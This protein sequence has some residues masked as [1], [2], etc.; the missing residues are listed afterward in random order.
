MKRREFLKQGAA[1]AVAGTAF[2][3]SAAAGTS[4]VG[5]AVAA[6]TGMGSALT[7]P[8]E[9]PSSLPAAPG[10]GP[11]I[12]PTPRGRGAGQRRF[13]LDYAPHFGM[14][15]QS[16]GDDLVDQLRFMADQ[17]F[18]AF[19]DNGMRGRPVEEQEAHRRARWNASACAWGCSSPTRSPG[20]NRTCRS[21][22]PDERRE[23]FLDEMPSVGRGRQARQR[24]LDDRRSR[25][26]RRRASTWTTRPP[27][28]IE[29]LQR[30]AEILEPH[31]LVMVLEPL[32]PCATTRACS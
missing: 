25:P 13:K 3:G 22:D 29:I 20:A 5:S 10:S 18:T 2:A 31:G 1:A 21:G 32:N 9:D 11:A 12:A 24:H 23:Q 6:T 8:T 14:F 7:A 28:S 16:A 30:A 19:E 26:R 4:V 27:T 17:G 15:R